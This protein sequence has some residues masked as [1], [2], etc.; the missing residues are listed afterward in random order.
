MVELVRLGRRQSR[1]R[2]VEPQAAQRFGGIAVGDA[3][4]AADHHRLAGGA[5]RR[6]QMRQPELAR[7]RL[8]RQRA[9]G[10]DAQR[11]VGEGLDLHLAPDA[12]GRRDRADADARFG[13]AGSSL[14][15]G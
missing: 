12:M 15:G 11:I 4:D 3:V 10:S 14:P 2:H 9:V 13:R 6:A 7:T 5:A 1:A 8:V